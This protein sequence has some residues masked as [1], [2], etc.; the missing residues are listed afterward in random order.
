MFKIQITDNYASVWSSILGYSNIPFIKSTSSKF[1]HAFYEF[2]QLQ[3]KIL[4]D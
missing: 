2:A 3:V 1:G 4:F